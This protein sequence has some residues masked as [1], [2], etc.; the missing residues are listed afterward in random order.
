MAVS[1]DLDRTDSFAVVDT[2]MEDTAEVATGEMAAGNTMELVVGVG[3]LLAA[4]V[5]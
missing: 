4:A 5:Y 2:V 3:I 1:E